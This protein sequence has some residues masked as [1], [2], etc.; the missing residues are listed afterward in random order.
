MESPATN[1]KF[2]VEV[3]NDRAIVLALDRNAD[4]IA[5][6]WQGAYELAALMKQV[7]DDVKDE[8][9]P[10]N[11]SVLLD[12]QYQIKLNVYRGLVCLVFAWGNRFKYHWRSFQV[13]QQALMIKIQDVQF[14]EQK[15]VVMPTLSRKHAKAIPKLR[16]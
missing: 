13:L 14:A 12:E 11:V 6:T 2:S 3:E 15:G 16:M 9:D 10:V 7:I 5:L 8:N 4:T 1:V